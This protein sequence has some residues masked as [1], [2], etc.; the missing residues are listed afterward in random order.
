MHQLNDLKIPCINH[1]IWVGSIPPADIID[2]IIFQALYL[3]KCFNAHP[4]ASN[5][6]FTEMKHWLWTST[7]YYPKLQKLRDLALENTGLILSPKMKKF[8]Q[9]KCIEKDLLDNPSFAQALENSP[10]D[11]NFF[12]IDQQLQKDLQLFWDFLKT[13]P[14]AILLPHFNYDRKKFEKFPCRLKKQAAAP[15]KMQI[16]ACYIQ[17]ETEGALANP[18]IAKDILEFLIPRFY[19]GL[20]HDAGLEINFNEFKSRC[21]PKLRETLANESLILQTK[22]FRDEL[23]RYR[24]RQRWVDEILL[25]NRFKAK[26]IYHMPIALDL[27]VQA[28]YFDP[29]YSGTKE[30]LNKILDGF[31]LCYILGMQES[32]RLERLCYAPWVSITMNI[33]QAVIFRYYQDIKRAWFKENG[34]DIIEDYENTLPSK[35]MSSL[36]KRLSPD[37]MEKEDI[38]ESFVFKNNPNKGF[39]AFP[40]IQQKGRQQSFNNYRLLSSYSTRTENNEKIQKGAHYDIIMVKKLE[41]L[42]SKIKPNTIYFLQL[43]EEKIILQYR[44]AAAQVITKTFNINLSQPLPQLEPGSSLLPFLKNA[45]INEIL[46]ETVRPILGLSESAI[47]SLKG[48]NQRL[49]YFK[50]IEKESDTPF[51]QDKEYK[52]P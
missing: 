12:S 16:L 47:P 2:K 46:K 29:R 7:S 17:N 44:N 39:E 4:V 9:I 20:V 48:F 40:A 43:E 19:G 13:H 23:D 1:T 26:D 8:I 11:F 49:R 10:F 35:E 18:A 36:I 22:P 30:F 50:M 3:E 5:D 42:P 25:S 41:E 6:P 27:D 28:A 33:L 52:V 32:V 45:T 37:L 31:I 24:F 15:L 38:K 34:I 21:L 14:S 51:L